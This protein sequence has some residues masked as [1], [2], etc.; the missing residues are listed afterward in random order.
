MKAERPKGGCVGRAALACVLLAAGLGSI[1]GFAP[2]PG[3]P[4]EPPLRGELM[5]AAVIVR[6]GGVNRVVPFLKADQKSPTYALGVMSR[7][8]SRV[9]REIGFDSGGDSL[10]SGA[11]PKIKPGLY[12]RSAEWEYELFDAYRLDRGNPT[13]GAPPSLS[14][15]TVEGLRAQIVEALNAGG[16]GRGD[17]FEAMLKGPLTRETMWCWQ[18]ACAVGA[19]ALLLVA[20]A[21]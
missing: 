10:L 12:R 18:N 4:A 20:W 6:Q 21:L 8:T 2:P 15:E 5:G 17:Q 1:A 3:P 14:K 9:S 13:D 19:Y 16:A 11:R 7:V